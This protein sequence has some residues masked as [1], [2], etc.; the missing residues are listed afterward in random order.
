MDVRE[1]KQICIIPA[2]SCS[3]QRWFWFFSISRKMENE[4]ATPRSFF[5]KD[6]DIEMIKHAASGRNGK[7]M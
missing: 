5:H 1:Q 4:A 3:F 6:V 2:E 7:L